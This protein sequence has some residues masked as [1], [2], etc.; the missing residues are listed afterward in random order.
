MQSKQAVTCSGK[1]IRPCS[2]IAKNC[3]FRD[4]IINMQN[5]SAIPFSSFNTTVNSQL[6]APAVD[7]TGKFL[8]HVREGMGKQETKSLVDRGMYV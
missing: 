3:S 6:G 4:L 5:F 2:W 8:I 1:K 7:H